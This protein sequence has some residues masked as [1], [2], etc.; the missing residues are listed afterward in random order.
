MTA[1]YFV[2]TNLLVHARDASDTTKHHRARAWLSRLWTDRSGRLSIQVLNE[3]YVVMTRKLGAEQAL[4]RADIRDL[5][6]WR[7]TP[8]SDQLLERAWQI[9]DRF[10][11]NYWDTLI[12]SAAQ[13][14]ACRY[15]LT[16][17]LQADQELDGMTVVN[18][19]QHTPEEHV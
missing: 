4:V 16:E 5:R 13:L 15:L 3:Y 19:F 14:A 18:P 7:P 12:V 17:D 9:Q 2:D 1:T 10:K 8:L 6:A 11:F